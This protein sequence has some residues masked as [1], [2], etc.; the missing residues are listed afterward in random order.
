MHVLTHITDIDISE[1]LKSYVERRLHF[2][3]ARFGGRV[4]QVTVR[5]CG[6]GSAQNRCR[7]SVE[8]QP[9]GRVAV[10]E[11]DP[12]LFAAID[13]ATGRIGR[14]FGRELD[15]CRD[16]KVGRESVRTAA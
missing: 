10:E 11:I 3:L 16:A 15:R 7:I 4:G 14:L 2:A 8:V 5:I 6:D 12:D 9:F 1:A 13:R